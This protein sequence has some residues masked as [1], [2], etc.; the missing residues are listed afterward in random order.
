[1]G[2]DNIVSGP[3]GPPITF[4]E[5]AIPTPSQPGWLAAGSD[6]HVWFT[7]QSTAPPAVTKVSKDGGQFDLFKVPST[8]IGPRGM[9]AGPDGKVW[10][11]KQGGVASVTPDGVVVEYPA[12]NGGDS[13]GIALGPDGN[14]WFTQ[15]L[16][17]RIT[18]VTPDG[19][20][21]D[22]ALPNPASGPLA[23]ALG[24]DKNLWF[25][26]NAATGNRIGRIT[27][28][29]TISEFPI[30]TPGAGPT[31]M[32]A[33]ADGNLWFTE[34]DGR[35]IGKLTPDGQITEFGIP[36]GHR[37]FRITNGPDG[38]LWFTAT[39]AANTVGRVTPLGQISEYVVP[40]AG[41]DP[42]DIAVGPDQNLWFTELS[43][44]KLC[45]I[46]DLQGGGTAMPTAGTSGG[47]GELGG[48]RACMR[49]RDCP[50][51][52]MACGGDLCSS[53]TKL[54][55]LSVSGDPGACSADGDCWC[56]QRGATCSGGHCSFTT[57]AGVP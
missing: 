35:K 50:D 55:V 10:Y 3:P 9:V 43:A 48:D 26:E 49:D 57:L 56:S 2:G 38:N 12:P 22:F 29:G 42:Y 11:A 45:R 4:T 14:L 18:R 1:M 54:C 52:G 8:R 7:H 17:D 41:A 28:T 53:Q 13:A 24:P 16:H 27:P 20:F 6:D 44:N 19:K 30:P 21:T 33:G 34:Q 5:F 15:Q 36:S 37:P 46:T 23:I 47:G 31:G 25:T 51:S 39:G 40:T 32:A